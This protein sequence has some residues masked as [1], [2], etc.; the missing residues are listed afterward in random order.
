MLL[1]CLL[2]GVTQ[3]DKLSINNCRLPTFVV[4]IEGKYVVFSMG[5]SMAPLRRLISMPTP[6]WP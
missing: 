4:D 2:L 5:P 3:Q 6:G 1:G